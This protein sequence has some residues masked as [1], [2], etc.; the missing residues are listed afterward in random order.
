MKRF[1]IRN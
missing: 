1:Q